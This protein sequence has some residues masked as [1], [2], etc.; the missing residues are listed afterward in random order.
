MFCL[1]FFDKKKTCRLDTVALE[2]LLPC[3]RSKTFFV[4]L[5]Y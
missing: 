4:V 5:V 2:D 1:G 3:S